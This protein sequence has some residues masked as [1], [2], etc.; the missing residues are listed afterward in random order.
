MKSCFGTIIPIGTA[1]VRKAI[2]RKSFQV[3]SAARGKSQ[4]RHKLDIDLKAWQAVNNVR[5]SAM[6]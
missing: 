2:S 4:D 6:L 1:T 5:T 3:A